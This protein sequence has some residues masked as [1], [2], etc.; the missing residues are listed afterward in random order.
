MNPIKSIKNFFF[1]KNFM[2]EML[3]GRERGVSVIQLGQDR[4]V[5]HKYGAFFLKFFEWLP[6]VGQIIFFI[7]GRK[8]RKE[9]NRNERRKRRN[10]RKKKNR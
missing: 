3:S 8:E 2:G 9:I 10:I 1:P 5:R 4:V 6:I 7:E